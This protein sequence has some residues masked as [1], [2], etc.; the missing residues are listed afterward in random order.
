LPTSCW[1]AKAGSK[2]D[3]GILPG[4][5][6]NSDAFM[7]LVTVCLLSFSTDFTFTICFFYFLHEQKVAKILG[8][9][10]MLAFL[11]RGIIAQYKA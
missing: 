11:G 9:V 10:K 2:R 4:K 5:I 8:F 7:F 3:S 6:V 1:G